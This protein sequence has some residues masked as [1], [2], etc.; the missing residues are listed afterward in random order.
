MMALARNAVLKTLLAGI[1]FVPLADEAIH[2]AIPVTVVDV[3]GESHAGTLAGLAANEIS[4]SIGDQ[5][6]TFSTRDVLEIRFNQKRTKPNL[7]SAAIFLANGDR[8]VASP[9]TIDDTK[10]IARW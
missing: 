4:L 6:R 8:L 3:Q 5:P 9:E 2:A 10:A 7:S 1:F